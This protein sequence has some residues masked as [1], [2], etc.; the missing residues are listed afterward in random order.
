M[1]LKLIEKFSFFFYVSVSMWKVVRK[2]GGFRVVW[3][4]FILINLLW[5]LLFL[6]EHEMFWFCLSL[7]VGG[8]WIKNHKKICLSHIP[9][10]PSHKHNRKIGYKM[11]LLTERTK[12]FYV[13][14]LYDFFMI[15]YLFLLCAQFLFIEIFFCIK[16]IDIKFAFCS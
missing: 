2:I 16:F 10:T 6:C 5:F 1:F 14:W 13:S 12:F 4:I 15:F 9:H 3:F 8:W 7:R 11:F